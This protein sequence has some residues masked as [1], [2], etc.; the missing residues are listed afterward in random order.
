MSP[1][2]NPRH[3]S[4]TTNNRVPDCRGD[5][6][7]LSLPEDGD[8]RVLHRADPRQGREHDNRLEDRGQLP[9][10][11]VTAF[12]AEAGRHTFR[13]VAQSDCGEHPST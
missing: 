3:T 7:D 13:G 11:H 5:V 6:P 4:G 8:D 1:C 12:H 9:R 2:E 10:H